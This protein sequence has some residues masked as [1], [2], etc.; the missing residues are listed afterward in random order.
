[1]SVAASVASVPSLA[2][3]SPLAQATP[4]AELLAVGEGVLEAVAT[5]FTT[6]ADGLGFLRGSA[7]L[8]EEQ[9]GID[10]Q[11]VC[12]SL[13]T[14]VFFLIHRCAHPSMTLA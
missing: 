13:P 1:M 2:L 6:L 7:T 10:A 4:D 8:G 14:V 3:P 5:D 9:I 11:T 12:G